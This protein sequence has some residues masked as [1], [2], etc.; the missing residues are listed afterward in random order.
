MYATKGVRE[1][2][3]SGPPP[4][5]TIAPGWKRSGCQRAQTAASELHLMVGQVEL[6]CESQHNKATVLPV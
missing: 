4:C 3:K 2:F 6:G 5:S 1:K